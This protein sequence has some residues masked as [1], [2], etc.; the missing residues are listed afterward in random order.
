MQKPK[1]YVIT[2]L[3]ALKKGDVVEW[4]DGYLVILD[5]PVKDI[6]SSKEMRESVIKVP[7]NFI[8]QGNR[9]LTKTTDRSIYREKKFLKGFTHL[10]Y[11]RIILNEEFKQ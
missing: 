1:P 8:D 10:T 9:Y 4:L 11:K 7:V 2:P 6:K 5:D 3:V